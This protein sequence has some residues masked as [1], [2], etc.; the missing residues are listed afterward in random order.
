M[1][2]SR[3][4]QFLAC[5]RIRRRAIFLVQVCEL[6]LLIGS[7]R[8][9]AIYES[10]YTKA[11]ADDATCTQLQQ[12]KRLKRKREKKKG[13]NK[14]TFK[15]KKYIVYN[16]FQL[17]KYKWRR[18]KCCDDGCKS[19]YTLGHKSPH[20]DTAFMYFKPHCELLP[21]SGIL[22]NIIHIC[23]TNFSYIKAAPRRL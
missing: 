18:C 17:H 14:D 9:F 5:W 12:E 21:P 8:G 19:Y 2:L 1:P 4:W 3:G 6:A 15:S 10:F 7:S 11:L 13:E 23:H 22:V 20:W 16:H